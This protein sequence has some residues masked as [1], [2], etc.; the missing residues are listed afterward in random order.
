M[1]LENINALKQN[2]E[3][4]RFYRML[5]PD[6]LDYLPKA[7]LEEYTQAYARYLRFDSKQSYVSATFYWKRAYSNHSSI[8]RD[9]KTSFKRLKTSRAALA[10]LVPGLPLAN[11][12]L[13]LQRAY[14]ALDPYTYEAK[15]RDPRYARALLHLR[16]LMKRKAYLE[17]QS[18][19]LKLNNKADRQAH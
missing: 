11:W 3:K 10:S 17:S 18:D 19:Y 7:L 12:P 8:R 9:Y 2:L 13:E 14:A 4:R 5:T 15:Y 1:T 6:P 16:E